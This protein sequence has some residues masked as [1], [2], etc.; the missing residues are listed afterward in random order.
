VTDVTSSYFAF[1]KLSVDLFFS[2]LNCFYKLRR[3]LTNLKIRSFLSFFF[4]EKEE[5]LFSPSLES[6]FKNEGLKNFN[7]RNSVALLI[8]Q[9]L[10]TCQDRFKGDRDV[11]YKQALKIIKHAAS[12]K[13]RFIKKHE[14]LN[15]SA[16]LPSIEFTAVVLAVQSTLEPDG[17]LKLSVFTK[18][19]EKVDRVKK[20]KQFIFKY[21]RKRFKKQEKLFFLE[22]SQLYRMQALFLEAMNWNLEL[23]KV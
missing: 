11:V 14:D 22:T 13:K 10:I 15:H 5:P 20:E 4:K 1:Q 18:I 8:I 19:I 7:Y 17:D 9:L 23:L 6:S 16:Y 12:L 21:N 2:T 3:D